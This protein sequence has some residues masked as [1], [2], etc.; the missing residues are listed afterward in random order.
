MGIPTSAQMDTSPRPPPPGTAR[1]L[2]LKDERLVIENLPAYGLRPDASTGCYPTTSHSQNAIR[3][4]PERERL[5]HN[6]SFYEE[7]R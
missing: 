2:A 4:L 7:R 1:R 3:N 6:L 5:V